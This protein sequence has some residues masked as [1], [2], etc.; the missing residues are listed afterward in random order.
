MQ[1]LA[2]TGNEGLSN[3]S[4][5]NWISG[6]VKKISVDKRFK[7]PHMGWNCLNFDKFHPLF[8]DIHINDHFYFQ[9]QDYLQELLA[10]LYNLYLKSSL[11]LK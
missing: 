5:L 9:K 3:N 2:T 8:K 1:L 7:I 4:G 10:I 6:E 11:I